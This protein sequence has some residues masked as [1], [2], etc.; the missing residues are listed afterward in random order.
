[1]LKITDGYRIVQQTRIIN[2]KIQEAFFEIRENFDMSAYGY[3]CDHSKNGIIPR[4]AVGISNSGSCAIC[5]D[6]ILDAVKEIY[7]LIILQPDNI[8]EK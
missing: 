2:N 1:M 6:C 4:V 8:I 3:E 5:I 7:G